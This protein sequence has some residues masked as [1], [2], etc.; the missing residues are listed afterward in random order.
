MF[1]SCYTCH[2]PFTSVALF[3]VDVMLS[4]IQLF[5]LFSCSPTLII[6]PSIYRYLTM[7][8]SLHPYSSLPLHLPTATSPYLC[9]SLPLKHHPSLHH[10]YLH[11]YP[12]LLLPTSISPCL[13]ISLPLNYDP[14]LHHP[15]VYISTSISPYGYSKTGSDSNINVGISFKLLKK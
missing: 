14:S 8:I 13:H 9:S 7:S 3:I 5:Q 2:V 10:P 1:S 15:Y 4:V 12:Y 11:I 6:L